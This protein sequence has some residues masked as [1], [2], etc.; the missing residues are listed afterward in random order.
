MAKDV[1]LTLESV[2]YSGKSIGDDIHIEIKT[3][4]QPKPFD[5]K[6]KAGT[7]K[8]LNK[9]IETLRT[10]G[11]SLTLP[12]TIKIIE[13]DRMLNDVGGMEGKI[14]VDTSQPH[15]LNKV[16]R[17]KVIESRWA[18]KKPEAFFDVT[19]KIQVKDRFHY[20]RELEEGWLNVT[21]GNKKEALPSFLKI[22]LNREEAKLQYFTILEGP[23]KGKEARVK[24]NDDGSSFLSEGNPYTDPVKMTYS[25]SK[26][27]LTVNRK[28]YKTRDYPASQLS[29]GLYKVLLPD[30]PH[31]G[32]EAYK[33]VA[34]KAKVWFRVGRDGE[35]YIH[36]GTYSLGCVTLIENSRW[37]ALYAVLIRSRTGDD[38]NIALL[39]VID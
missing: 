24:Y 31:A 10:E 20:I 23:Y 28:S 36:T 26:K 11:Q 34:K 25:I 9:E 35:R 6:I 33:D 12:L 30:Y 29:K 3:T 37:D 21:I 4:D 17:I 18:L 39:K 14:E 22:Q 38:R 13:K 7:T 32:G 2:T 27:I 19:F 1:V 15:T 16:Y 5:E 8:K